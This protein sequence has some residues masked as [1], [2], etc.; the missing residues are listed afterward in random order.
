[1]IYNADYVTNSSSTSFVLILKDKRHFTLESFLNAAGVLEDSPLVIVYKRLFQLINENVSDKT[2]VS[3]EEI[4]EEYRSFD[5]FSKEGEEEI[6]RRIKNGEKAYVGTISDDDLVGGYYMGNRIIIV[7]DT[8]Y[9]NWE[10]DA[11]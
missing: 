4:N 6:R 11:Y 8:F 3:F 1:M 9:F 10:P 5:E 2:I 7:G